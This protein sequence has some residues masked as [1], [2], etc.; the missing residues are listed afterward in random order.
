VAAD[1]LSHC[2][3]KM[4]GAISSCAPSWQENLATG[5]HGNEEDKKMLADLSMPGTHPVGLSL[6]DGLIRFKSR[7]WVGHN[8]LA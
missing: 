5:Y 4:V 1:A 2:E 6:V 8:S 7:I 3:T